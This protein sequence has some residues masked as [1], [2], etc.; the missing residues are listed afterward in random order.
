MEHL[1]D[2]WAGPEC[3]TELLNKKKGEIMTKIFSNPK[4]FHATR[5]SLWPLKTWEN[6][7]FSDVFR[8]HRERDQLHEI[9]TFY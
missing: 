7:S 6:Q 8:D 5:L 4:P 1:I 9:G 2:V 3:T